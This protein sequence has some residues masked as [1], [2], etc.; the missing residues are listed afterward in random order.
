MI[1]TRFTRMLSR[2]KASALAV[3]CGDHSNGQRGNFALPLAA[4]LAL[5]SGGVSFAQVSGHSANVEQ[6]TQVAKVHAYWTSQRLASAKTMTLMPQL[7]VD[8]LPAAASSTRPAAGVTSANGKGSL[9]LV[10]AQPSAQQQLVQPSDLAQAA[11]NLA[12]D[13]MLATQ[14]QNIPLASSSYG[15]FFT[16]N[17]VSP[18][19]ATTSYPY[20]TIGKLFFTDPRTGGN[21]VCS[22]SVLRPRIIATAG[23]CVTQ[24]STSAAGRYFY[25][26][27]LFVPAYRNGVAPF[28]SF[29]PSIEWVTNTWY[30]S[31]GSVPNPQDVAIIVARDTT[32]KLGYITGWLGWRTNGLPAN[33]L[34]VGGYPCNLDSCARMEQT[35]AQIFA[36]GGNNT[37][38]VGSAM[39]GGA[40]GGPWIQDFGIA[41]VGA[42]AGELALNYLVGVTSYGP[43]STTPQ[44]LGASNFDGD[45]INLLNSACGAATSGNCN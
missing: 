37:Y 25:T 10:A 14:E 3:A 7:G 4:L 39:R 36:F 19:A 22:A 26:N 12:A 24:P 18:D 34:L 6:V 35:W 40:S 45:F 28:G 27:F 31:D 44:Y 23:H 17:R 2:S 11:V 8:G 15:A 16:T 38:T 30:F 32:S 1:Y 41:P 43:T 33:N 13:T 5:S 29:T 9:P 42:P 21:F 20:S